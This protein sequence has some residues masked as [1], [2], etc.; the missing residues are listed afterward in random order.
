M[1]FPV[2]FITMTPHLIATLVKYII[3]LI[4]YA[5]KFIVH[6]VVFAIST[7]IF[8]L[9]LT[10]ILIGWLA[11]L[12]YETIKSPFQYFIDGENA[13]YFVILKDINVRIRRFKDMYMSLYTF[14]K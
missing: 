11:V 5:Y 13:Q 3:L 6:I 1:L 7:S 12:I 2:V 14:S 8:I 9:I 10:P 4:L